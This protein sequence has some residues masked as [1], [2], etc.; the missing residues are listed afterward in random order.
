MLWYG[1]QKG[2]VDES[3]RLTVPYWQIHAPPSEEMIALNPGNAYWTFVPSACAIKMIQRKR[4]H[5]YILT[6]G[7]ETQ[8]AAHRFGT[9][10]LTNQRSPAMALR[11]PN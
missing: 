11:L 1:L 2:C 3:C 7:R 5:F 9:L 6:F 10:I 8:F 4:E